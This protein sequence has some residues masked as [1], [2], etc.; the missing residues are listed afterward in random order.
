MSREQFDKSDPLTSVENPDTPRINA[1]LDAT[2]ADDGI[3]FLNVVREGRKLERDLAKARDRMANAELDRDAHAEDSRQKD[4]RIARL[5]AASRPSQLTQEPMAWM[6]TPPRGNKSL[7]FQDASK[8]E[9]WLD[10]KVADGYAITPLYAAPQSAPSPLA[11]MRHE[12]PEA[13]ACALLLEWV[14]EGKNGMP[15]EG[16]LDDAVTFA[17]QAVGQIEV[18]LAVSTQLPKEPK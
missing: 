17:R 7:T 6:I 2:V 11:T 18:S 10:G 16:T 9:F 12:R 4:E 1:A 14:A 15:D 13:K 5:V 3:T 8:P